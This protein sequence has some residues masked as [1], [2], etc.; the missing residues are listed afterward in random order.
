[1][2]SPRTR[3]SPL[4]PDANGALSMCLETN[5]EYLDVAE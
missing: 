2:A 1:M 4:S 5:V 3:P